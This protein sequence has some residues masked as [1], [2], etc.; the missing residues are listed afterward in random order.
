VNILRREDFPQMKAL[1]RAEQILRE[2][3]HKG[4]V[5]LEELISGLGASA[6]SVRRDLAKLEGKASSGELTAAPSW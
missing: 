1:N 2:L 6:A 5:S 4:S 3:R